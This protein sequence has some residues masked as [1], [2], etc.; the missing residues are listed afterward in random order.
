M[1]MHR[2]TQTGQ[3]LPLFALLL[4]LLI[5]LLT[6][7]YV[8]G[9]VLQAQTMTT[10]TARSLALDAMSQVN[11]GVL[12]GRTIQ[13]SL[14]NLASSS[15]YPAIVTQSPIP[16]SASNTLQVSGVYVTTF[17]AATTPLTSAAIPVSTNEVRV[18]VAI[19]LHVGWG[20]LALP[21]FQISSATTALDAGAAIKLM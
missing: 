4:P 16:S 13:A 11:R 2:S 12:N 7:T 20:R 6:F 5:T 1:C 14:M 10:S 9:R 15:G 18:H 21:D 8:Y 19:R 3:I 17:A